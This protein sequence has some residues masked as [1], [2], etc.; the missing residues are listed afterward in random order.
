[1]QTIQ[2]LRQL[3]Q[4]DGVAGGEDHALTAV[5]QGRLTDQVAGLKNFPDTHVASGAGGASAP[6]AGCTHRRDWSDRYPY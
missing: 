5:P 1:M 4:V 3:T 2:M 6:A